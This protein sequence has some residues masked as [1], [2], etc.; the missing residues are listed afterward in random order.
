MKGFPYGAAAFC[1]LVCAIVSGIWLSFH[2]VKK[3]DADL[4]FWTFAKPHAE[5]YRKLIPIFEKEH[6]CKVDLQLVA[7]SVVGQRLEAAFWANL[8]VPDLVEI[9][10]G[11]VGTFFRG[12]LQDVGFSDLTDRIKEGGDNSV[13]NRFVQQRFSPYTKKGRIFGLPHDVHPVQFAYRRDLFEQLGID[14]SKINTW[15]DYIQIAHKVVKPGERY[16]CDFDQTNYGIEVCLYQHDGGY[17]DADGNCTIDNEAAVQTMLWYVPLVAGP[18]RIGKFLGW[19]PSLTNA[20]EDGYNLCVICPDWRSKTITDD[21]GPMSGKMAL[22]PLPRLT[23]TSR[24]TSTWG[25][26][27]FG[28]TKH[29]KN[30]D[31]AWE[32][33]KYLY[34]NKEALAQ[35]YTVTQIIPPL[36]EAWALP[37]FHYKNP[38]WSNME[39]GASYAKLAP[40]IPNKYSSPFLT[41]ATD[42]LNDSLLDCSAYYEKHGNDGFEPFVRAELKKK[43]DEVREIMART[44]Y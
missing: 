33:A 39:V 21:I 27:M 5:S 2:G 3:T 26:T 7:Q 30:Q 29:C 12:P 34:T 31:L 13:W 9:N 24:P 32:L 22:M 18:N 1:F 14:P 11:D 6:H 4:T 43:A 44:P 15:D 40:E 28:I 10:S 41:Q 37:Q 25:G 17:F 23:P 42:R 36:K 35:L 38:Y 20:V 8:D 19:G 16:M